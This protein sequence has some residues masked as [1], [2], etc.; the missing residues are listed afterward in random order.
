[1]LGELDLQQELRDQWVYSRLVPEDYLLRQL[2]R[3]LDF[4]FVEEETRDLYSPDTGHASY[5]PQQ[6]FKVLLGAY[7]Y[8]LSDV[9]VTQEFRYNL[10]YRAS[11]GFGLNDDTPDDSTLVVF[12]RRLGEERFG[13]LFDRVVERAVELGFLQGQRELVDATAIR[14]AA[15]LR[16][17]RELLREVRRRVLRE[18][19][20]YDYARAKCLAL[21]E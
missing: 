3:A 18:L 6:L 2:E 9:R 7:L 21:G 15:A 10:L 17:R 4:G 16:N 5:P 14:A 8:G 1:V 12:C 20:R 19:A 11:C 13:R